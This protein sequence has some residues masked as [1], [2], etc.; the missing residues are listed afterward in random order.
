[1][2]FHEQLESIIG[3]R[4]SGDGHAGTIEGYLQEELP[5][6]YA[7]MLRYFEG[8]GEHSQ[9]LNCCPEHR[10]GALMQIWCTGAAVAIKLY[11]MYGEPEDLRSLLEEGEE[12]Q[13]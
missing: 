9:D 2:K 6:H 13:S 1:M 4:K 5:R 10:G 12:R 8:M 7:A 11:Q 3:P